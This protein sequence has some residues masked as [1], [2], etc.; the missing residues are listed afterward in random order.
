MYR[1]QYHSSNSYLNTSDSN[2][3]SSEPQQNI[4]DMEKL[5]DMCNKTVYC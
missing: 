5:L 2:S 4:P 3:I 1:F